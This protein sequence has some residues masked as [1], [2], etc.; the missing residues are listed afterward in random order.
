MGLRPNLIIN[1]QMAG[2][3]GCGF[4][5]ITLKMESES[6]E[7]TSTSDKTTSQEVNK[8]V[9]SWIIDYYFATLCR[10][11][12]ERSS[13]EFRKDLK[14]FEGLVDELE[15]HSSQRTVCCFLAR[16]MDG[17]NLN[18]RYDHVAR[19]T[20]LMSAVPVWESLKDFSEPTLHGKIQTLL[21][22]QSVAVCVK[23][24]YDK[25]AKETLQWLEEQTD[26]PEKLQRKLATIVNKKDTY[27]QI[28]MN[29]SFDK[30][31]E[32]IDTFLEAFNQ[33][34]ASI[35]LLEA[36]SK[37]VQARHER[38]E[39]TPSELEGAGE[40]PPSPQSD[41][42]ESENEEH[43]D[44]LVGNIRP[45]RKLLPKQ[46]DPWK[47]ET[48][49]KAHAT[50]KRTSICKVTRRSNTPSEL[51]SNITVAS[52]SR[53]KW[54]DVEDRKLKAGVKKHGVGK[55]SKILNDFDFD[56]R[57]TVNLKDR[58]RVLKKLDRVS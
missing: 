3:F 26:V 5:N 45:K 12:R 15:S 53:K 23:K 8:V 4:I 58:W 28:L 7:I 14:L 11:F 52:H 25:L 36:A 41:K 19:I 40:M 57:T 56:N 46:N 34:Y 21:M 44:P 32:T 9:Q 18:V 47:P 51:H 39:E 27:D 2:T 1:K 17:E 37:V 55:W 33:Q 30:L 48:A 31:M 29:F 13:V 16:V 54:T 38:S 20:P 43:G 10:L 35:F 6:Y 50:L 49:K 42:S 22:V 24:G